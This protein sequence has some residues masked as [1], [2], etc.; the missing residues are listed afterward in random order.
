MTNQNH[1]LVIMEGQVVVIREV[2][3]LLVVVAL[4]VVPQKNVAHVK[5]QDH[6]GHATVLVY[7]DLIKYAEH[8]KGRVIAS[9]VEEVAKDNN[10]TNRVLLYLYSF[11]FFEQTSIC[12]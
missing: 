3:T 5:A 6:V 7:M 11:V 4:V 9:G 8:V 12:S 2:A 10:K 1:I